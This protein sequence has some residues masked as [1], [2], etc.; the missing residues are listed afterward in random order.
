MNRKKSK[1]IR[2]HAETLQIEWLKSLLSDEEASKITKDNFKDMLPQQTHLWAQGT[3]HTSFY[4]LKW[5][6]NKIK[7]LIK[8]FPDKDVEDITPQD[9][10]WKMEQ[11]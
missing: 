9:I 6:S 2:K 3:I 10:A 1:R 8:I 5:L 4:T 7:Q 11:R